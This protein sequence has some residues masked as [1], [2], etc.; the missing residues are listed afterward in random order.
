MCSQTKGRQ[1]TSAEFQEFVRCYQFEILHS[2]PRYP[3]SNGFIEAMAKFFKQTTSKLE[4]SWKD[5]HLTILAHRVTARGPRKL[6]PAEVMAQC[7][8]RALLP[9]KQHLSAQLSTSRKIMLPKN[10]NRHITTTAK[11]G[12]SKNSNSTNHFEYKSWATN[13]EESNS[14]WDTHKESP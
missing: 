8:F 7:K 12:N 13:L 9:I 3:H 2:T 14:H 5:P 11:H 1:L 6:S 10:S 4:Q